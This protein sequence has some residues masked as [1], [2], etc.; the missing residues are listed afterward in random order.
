MTT[1]TN[2]DEQIVPAL[3]A[4]DRESLENFGMTLAD[5]QEEAE[6]MR[7]AEQ[8]N[9]Y[10][11]EGVTNYQERTTTMTIKHP[12]HVPLTLAESER[13]D[14]AL[15]LASRAYRQRLPGPTLAAG[16]D[17]QPAA[18]TSPTAVTALDDVAAMLT[19]TRLD[20]LSD[21]LRR[22]DGSPQDDIQVTLNPDDDDD[23]P[24]AAAH[25]LTLTYDNHPAAPAHLLLLAMFLANREAA[26]AHAPTLR[27]LERLISGGR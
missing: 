18:P 4:E 23:S 8:A 7:R 12:K 5:C 1:F 21:A 14:D 26:P 27:L 6:G 19:L 11:L 2:T 10:A 22:A 17:D 15:R 13:L 24:G 3:S 25:E 16:V 20:A 9:E